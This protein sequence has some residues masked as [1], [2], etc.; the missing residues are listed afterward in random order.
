[1]AHI[2]LLCLGATGHLNTMFPLG[3]ELQQRGHQVTVLSTPDVYP[4]ARVAGFNFC[5]I[6]T[7]I[8]RQSTSKFTPSTKLVTLTGINRTFQNFA[9]YAEVRLQNTD[10][11]REQGLE[12]LLV[13]LSVFE[14]GT[15]AEHLDIPYI[16]IC[17][18]LPFYQDP[19]IP[20]IATTWAYNLAW[21]A[22]M[23]NRAAYKLFN[24]MAQ[25]V[26]QVI[27]RYRQQWNLSA[28]QHPNDIFSKLA[29]ITR[30]I[31]EFEFPRQL[32]P[33]F[34]FTGSFHQAIAREPV[35]FP[36]EQLNGK[37]LIYASMGTLQNRS[38]VVFQTI[39]AACADLNAQLV[40]SL[41]GGLEP[42]AFSDLPGSPLV[43]K[44][45]PQLEL[46]Q[47]ASLNITHAGLNTTLES[48]SYGVPMVAIP[49]TDDQP[50]VAAR[51]QWTGSGE[52]VEL[53][54]LSVSKLRG[55]IARVLTEETYQ[56][57]AVRLQAIMRQTKGVHRAVDIIEQAVFTGSP[58]T[59]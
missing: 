17:C 18:I 25:P 48:L 1:M 36:F 56:Q 38:T 30:H 14:G 10:L 43:V 24:W 31:P 33:H 32:P 23:R 15:I 44:Y 35:A 54:Q 29:I 5:N 51:I 53:S 52:L 55:A 50:G 16:T 41:G 59:D 42:Q 2:G 8:D 58:V 12:A 22:Q 27:S 45:A 40:I 26:L 47:K 4:K 37:P 3:H 6:Y 57:N 49:V 20:P 46:L 34:H 7:T 9:H 39:A 11:I 19:T 28:Y 21:W 13:D